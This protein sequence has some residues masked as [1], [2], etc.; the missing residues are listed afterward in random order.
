MGRRGRGWWRRV[1]CKLVDYGPAAFLA[2]GLIFLCNF[3]PIAAFFE[4]ELK[5]AEVLGMFWQLFVL[6][7]A[8][9]A[10]YFF[11][12]YHQWLLATIVLAG[13]VVFV[14]VRGSLSQKTPATGR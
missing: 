10:L 4:E 11:D 9:P 14:V 8:S 12:S 7:A 3:R 13:I 6:G 5:G 1:A 2:T